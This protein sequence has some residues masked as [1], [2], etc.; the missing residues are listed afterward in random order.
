ML[1]PS[2]RCPAFFPTEKKERKHLETHSLEHNLFLL[3]SERI[4]AAVF[5]S[6]AEHRFLVTSDMRYNAN[7]VFSVLSFLV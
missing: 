1:F 7:F 2:A 3:S 4:L 5:L 6:P